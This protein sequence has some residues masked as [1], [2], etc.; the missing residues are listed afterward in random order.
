[1][2]LDTKELCISHQGV[3]LGEQKG[4]RSTKGG[5]R[6]PVLG[7]VIMTVWV[8]AR[9]YPGVQANGGHSVMI[10]QNRGKGLALCFDLIKG[11]HH[12]VTS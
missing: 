11:R 8:P 3:V 5:D 10:K 2:K 6:A 12:L 9:V 4:I 1:M 7:V